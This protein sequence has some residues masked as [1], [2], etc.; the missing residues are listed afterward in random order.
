[1]RGRIA[2][3][4]QLGKQTREGD[5]AAIAIVRPVSPTTHTKLEL[6]TDGDR[7]KGQEDEN[8]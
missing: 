4:V 6:D 7:A 3:G 5:Q 1:M 2:A 8:I